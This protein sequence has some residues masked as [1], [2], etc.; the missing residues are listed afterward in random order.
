MSVKRTKQIA[1]FTIFLLLVYSGIQI[2][3]NYYIPDQ[4]KILVGQERKLGYGFG[5]EAEISGEIKG[6]LMLN[7]KPVS[8]DKITVKMNESC[9]ISSQES[10]SFKIDYK[11][12]GLFH[13][14][15]VKVDVINPN[16]YIPCGQMI[17]V[18]IHT[19]GIMVLGTGEV[20]DVNGKIVSPASD[21]LLTG[22]YIQS[23]NGVTV[24]TKEELSKLVHASK[25]K[26]V[27]IGF[28]RNGKLLSTKIE[29]VAIG[30]NEYKL[31]VWVRDDTQG[32]GTL[33]FVNPAQNVFGA[34][35]HGITDV[36]TGLLMEL[37]GGTIVTSL[38]TNITPGEKGNPG[39]I[40]GVII[41]EEDKTIGLVE[42]N[43]PNGIFGHLTEA[44]ENVFSDTKSIP[45]GFK[46]EVH[47]GLAYIRSDVSGI[48]KDYEIQIEKIFLSDTTNKGMIIRVTDKNLLELTNGIIQGM[49]GSP[50]IQDGKLIG[51]VTHVFIQ[52]STKGYG[53]FIENMILEY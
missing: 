35:G 28:K 1:I 52:D 13:I 2:I 39:E 33:T 7:S 8:K 40:S 14:K 10:G 53:T 49:S 15:K 34:L 29:P 32:I 23:I 4:I 43:E 12:L 22:D 51:A 38:I 21:K 6:V 50:I 30:S 36:D 9:S 31:G 45:L 18:T 37:S 5:L 25:G 20:T 27:E 19:D 48:L 41:D 46:N 44:G 26:P 16:D 17:G 3:A 11:L 47:E 42:K 24:S